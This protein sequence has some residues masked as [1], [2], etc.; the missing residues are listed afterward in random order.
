MP[1]VT[2]YLLLTI[3][4][5]FVLILLYLIPEK[6]IFPPTFVINLDDRK[7]RMKEITEEFKLWPV[8]LE[9]ISAVKMSP[10][11]KGCTLSH[12]K[13]IHL[14]KERKYPWVLV[15]EDDCTLSKDSIDRFKEILPVLWKHKERWEIFN[16]GVST[17]HNHTLI[18]V[19]RKMFRVTA[20]STS[21]ILIHESV[22]DKILSFEEADPSQAIDVIYSQNFNMLTITPPS[23]T[24]EDK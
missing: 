21:F 2:V 23:V 10:G 13:C 8:P 18:D 3:L 5:I 15:L 16:G 14:A 1:K 11:F 17:L 12:L 7:D 4:I 9:R 22:Y 20:Y 24:S 6:I 19:P